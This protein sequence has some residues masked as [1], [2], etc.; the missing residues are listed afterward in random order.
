MKTIKFDE[1][2]RAI[3]SYCADEMGIPEKM[4]EQ[5]TKNYLIEKEQE[6]QK[7]LAEIKNITEL[8]DQELWDLRLSI[9][10]GSLYLSDYK[11]EYGIDKKIL[12]NFFDGYIDDLYEIAEEDGID[13]SGDCFIDIINNYDNMDNLINWRDCIEYDSEFL[14]EMT[15]EARETIE[16]EYSDIRD[17]IFG[18]EEI[19]YIAANLQYYLMARFAA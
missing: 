18:Q 8:T 7:R 5:A 11:N 16:A 14:D 6:K 13:V 19:Y 12:S 1:S 10:I 9:P 17:Y 2:E 4:L 3:I 15:A